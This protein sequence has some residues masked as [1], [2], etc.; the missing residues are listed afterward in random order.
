MRALFHVQTLLFNAVC[1]LRGE[2]HLHA[3]HN[4]KTAKPENS[5][6]ETTVCPG[7]ILC[8]G[9]SDPETK[10]VGAKLKHDYP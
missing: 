4:Y 1:Q 3:M 8:S 6:P 9:I 2:T 5:T 7:A 10:R